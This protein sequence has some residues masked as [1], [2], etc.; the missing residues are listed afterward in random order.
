MLNIKIKLY[1]DE[2]DLFR[3]QFTLINNCKNKNEEL[4]KIKEINE[5]KKKKNC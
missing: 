3:N 4:L 2:N 1:K 5:K